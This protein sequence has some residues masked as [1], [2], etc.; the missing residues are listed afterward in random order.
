VRR[1]PGLTVTLSRSAPAALIRAVGDGDPFAD[2]TLYSFIE[3][4]AR[5]RRRSWNVTAVVLP[6]FVAAAALFVTVGDVTGV[7]VGARGAAE[8]EVLRTPL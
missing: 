7:R 2:S 1:Q 3:P 4:P 6:K 8:S 5:G